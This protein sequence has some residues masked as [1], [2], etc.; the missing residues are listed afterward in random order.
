MRR[1]GM[2]LMF[3]AVAGLVAAGLGWLTAGTLREEEARRL[4]AQKAERSE[5]IRL[6]LWRLD[7]RMYLP[8]GLEAMRRYEDYTAL[9]TPPGEPVGGSQFLS[10]LV[11]VEL[12]DWMTLHLQLDPRTGWHSPQ[13]LSERA[14]ARLS[15]PEFELDLS[16]LSGSRT[17]LFRNV[18][19][20]FPVKATLSQ[21]Q[22][23]AGSLPDP[24]VVV[25]AGTADAN[26]NG[27][28]AV[29]YQ[30][31]ALMNEDQSNRQKSLDKN[32][33]NIKGAGQGLS[34]QV[35]PTEPSPQQGRGPGGRSNF[36]N[37]SARNGFMPMPPVAVH[38]GAMRPVW[39]SDADGQHALF[40]IRPARLAQATVYQGI[41]LDWPMLQKDLLDEI[42]DEFPEADLRPLTA[43]EPQPQPHQLASLPVVFEPGPP[44]PLPPAGWTPLRTGLLL[45]WLAATVALAAA[46]FAGSSLVALSERRMSFVSA[47]THELRTPLTS[48]RLYLDMLTSGLVTDE[49]KRQDY[50]TTL[51]HESD[52]L[53]QL[54]ENVLDFAKLEKRSATVAARPVAIGELIDHLRET[55]ADRLTAD[56]KEFIV[57]SKLPDDAALTTDPRIVQQVLGNLIDNARKYSAGAADPKIVLSIARD[58]TTVTFDVDDRGPGVPAGERRSIFRAFRRGEASGATG[59]AGL[60][61]AL[62]KQWAESLGGTV[63]CRPVADRPGAN[64]RLTLRM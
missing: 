29:P 62:A 33:L 45:A 58:G 44:P 48:L 23:L 61:L 21:L 35:P 50:L 32:L 55:W 36:T 30:S 12:P 4:N 38:L 7:A 56:G 40:I 20:R 37:P 54:I 26:D 5:T 43:P 57:D 10:P 13:V 24:T 18:Q 25:N 60:G 2:L 51:T 52:R 11:A 31:N 1:R 3:V 41:L 17:A 49:A 42:R 59:G 27:F 19:S 9:Y 63:E 64:F 53:H 15:N 47:V 22:S 39:L 16:N 46:W 14:I 28:N 6:A 8:L 34:Q